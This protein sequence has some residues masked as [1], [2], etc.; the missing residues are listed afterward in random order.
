M[1]WL[2]VLDCLVVICQVIHLHRRV[3]DLIIVVCKHLTSVFL[4]GRWM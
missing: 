2:L 3:P 4:H 1:P